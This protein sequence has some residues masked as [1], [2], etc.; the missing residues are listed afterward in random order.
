MFY[1]VN[2]DL[3]L[4]IYLYSPILFHSCFFFLLP[5][6]IIFFSLYCFLSVNS[7]CDKY[8]QFIF[9]KMSL[10]CLHFFLYFSMYVKVTQL[11]P[12]L[13]DFM[14]YTVHGVLQ[15]R[16]LEWVAYLLSSGSSWPRNWTRVS[17]IA[18]RF[19]TTWAIR[20]EF[21]IGNFFIS[22]LWNC[23]FSVFWLSSF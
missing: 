22:A 7:S 8:F 21:N 13:C 18:G 1:T 6:I 9:L 10:F 11:Y 20:E 4:L 5:S 14:D 15:A 23:N 19:F 12:I 16:I 3:L 2:I 17:C